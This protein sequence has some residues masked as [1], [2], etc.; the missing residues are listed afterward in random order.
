M[1]YSPRNIRIACDHAGLTH[2]GGVYFFH[3]FLQV[4]QLR[5]FLTQHLTLPASGVTQIRPYGVT[6]K[7]TNEKHFSTLQKWALPQ[8]PC[9]SGDIRSRRHL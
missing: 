3:E 7:P 5:N 9:N 8:F 4:L 6:S 1:P 2:Y